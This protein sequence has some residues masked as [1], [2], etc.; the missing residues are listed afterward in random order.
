M[1]LMLGDCVAEVHVL[2]EHSGPTVPR[3]LD[4]PGWRG[5]NPTMHGTSLV[6]RSSVA[7]PPKILVIHKNVNKSSA[8]AEMGDRLATIDIG[9]EVGGGCCGCGPFRGGGM[10][11]YLTQCRLGRGLPPY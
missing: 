6:T 9:R 1:T 7:L 10:G 8:V 5:V 3:R 4:I 2:R 11:P